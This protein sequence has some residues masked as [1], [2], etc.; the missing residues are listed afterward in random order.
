MSVSDMVLRVA[1]ASRGRRS[2]VRELGA[3]LREAL[4]ES[5]SA[6][7]VP[8]SVIVNDGVVSVRGEVDS[9]DEISRASRL[10]DRFR[11]GIEIDNLVRVRPSAVATRGGGGTRAGVISC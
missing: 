6:D 3:R 10:I 9:L 1:G 4:I 8:L 7:G 11:G 2:E 5:L